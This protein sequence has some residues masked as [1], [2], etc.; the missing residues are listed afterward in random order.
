MKDHALRHILHNEIHARPPE[1]VVGPMAISHLVL[2]YVNGNKQ[3]S[4]THL[5]QLLSSYQLPL[6]DGDTNHISVN[7]GMFR[8]RWELHTEFTSWTFIRT[9]NEKML[10][11]R[12]RPQT[13][14]GVVPQEW[15]DGLPG[16]T[17][18]KVHLWLLSSKEI[19]DENLVAEM[20][21][22]DTLVAST[23]A[24]GNGEVYTDF[25]IHPD[26]YSRIVLLAGSIAARRQ[27]RLVQ[28]LLEVET[29][30]MAALL[31]LPAA[32]SAGSV[33][34]DAEKELAELAKSIQT[35]TAQDEASLLDRLTR[36]AGVVEGQYAS[37]HSRFSASKAY[38]E[39]VDRRI[40]DIAETRLQ[41][42]QT[43][44][45]FMERRLTPAR[46]T[47]EWAAR[48]QTALS[49]RVSRMSNLLRTRVTFE[50]QQNSQQFLSTMNKRQ[51]LQLKLQATV[52]GLSITA[53][54]Y[55]IIGLTEQ[56]M[57]GAEKLGWIASPDI[58]TAISLPFVVGLVWWAIHRI[59]KKVLKN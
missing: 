58:A 54:S 20:L 19:A 42:M 55:Y 2:L 49:E 12:S 44:A 11:D 23:L 26:G 50:Q 3:A 15:L 35:A 59:H 32:R 29:Y 33:L 10:A 36:L 1:P 21:H 43:I 7:L 9:G 39:L 57:Q 46:S 41:G 16:E 22:E 14:T 24:E 47:C 53:I 5:Q 52:E 31:G 6:P 56:L 18:S 28:Q 13:A 48:R 27:G 37:T 25:Q 17:L 51:G 45:D 4:R 40:T 8:L 34:V 38:F 30:R